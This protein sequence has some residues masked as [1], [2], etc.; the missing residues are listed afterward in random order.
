MKAPLKIFLFGRKSAEKELSAWR[1][2]A[3]RENGRY[4]FISGKTSNLEVHHGFDVKTY[5]MFATSRWNDFVM[6]KAEHRAFHA[7]MGGT[8]VSCTPFHLFFWVYFVKKPW[9][10]FLVL[11]LSFFVCFLFVF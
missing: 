6:T 2:A 11:I 3:L 9:V 10:L 5:P 1:A 7:W 4:S 8:H